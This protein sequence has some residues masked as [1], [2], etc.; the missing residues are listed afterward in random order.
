M[1][2]Y[3]SDSDEEY[4]TTNCDGIEMGYS[5]N[6]VIR[7]NTDYNPCDTTN[8]DG[9]ETGLNLNINAHLNTTVYS[10]EILSSLQDTAGIPS[11]DWVYGKREWDDV[12]NCVIYGGNGLSV[13]AGD[14]NVLLQ[15]NNRA[16]IP[17]EIMDS[18]GKNLDNI[19][20]SGR[21]YLTHD[22]GIWIETSEPQK[23]I[24]LVEELEELIQLK[25]MIKELYWAPASSDG[26]PG[27]PGYQKAQSSYQSHV[28]HKDD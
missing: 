24:N 2:D 18:E 7:N 5:E 25:D 19:G 20:I 13:L 6:R 4:D 17:K 1:T 22:N 26:F 23:F 8:C 11:F 27:G 16:F 12:K 9:I 10:G 21:M 28:K 14:N 15:A 3:E